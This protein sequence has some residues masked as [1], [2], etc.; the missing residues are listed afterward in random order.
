MHL[1]GSEITIARSKVYP[2]HVHG[3]FRK[4]RNF[5]SFGLQALLFSLPWIEYNGRQAVLADLPGRKLYLFELVL[6]PQDTYFLHLMLISGALTL[7]LVSAVIGRTWCGYA[8]PQTIF[9]QAFIM[10]ERWFEGDR[11]ARMRLDKAPWDAGK[12]GRKVGK[13]ATWTLMGMWLGFTFSGYFLP[14]RHSLTQL[15]AGEVS[16]TTGITI[17]FFTAIS[18]FDFG[19]FR[20][21]FCCYLCPYA[22][23]Q[24]AMLDRDSLIVAYD[25]RR[26][27]P[28]GKVKDPGRGACIDCSACVQACPTGIDI[29]KGLQ[30]ECIACTAC[31]DACDEMMDKVNQ[32]RGLVRYSSLNGLEGNPQ[33]LVRPR[34]LVYGVLLSILGSLLGYLFWNRSPIGVDAV[35]VVQPGGQLALTTP[36]GRV[37]NIFKLSL[38]NRLNE[39]TE[40][41]VETQGLGEVQLA[42]LQQPVH[43][44][45]G[46]VVE[47]QVLLVAKQDLGRGGHPFKFIVRNQHQG[48]NWARANFFIP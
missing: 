38:V 33:K 46:Q 18:L 20:E 28:R 9:S 5:F 17:A 11:A 30:L 8:C 25:S 22:R 29:R 27:E 47:D 34:L 42:G 2:K 31:I 41:T 43:L 12:I 35:R 19:Y 14:I 16:M 32:P 48:D 13:L 40:F 15:L 23:F 39:A 3:R 37:T 26:G 44:D 1:P 10:V 4:L 7:F 21:Q 6:H 45:P 36:D 24:G